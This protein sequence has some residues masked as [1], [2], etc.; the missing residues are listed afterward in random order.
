L[1]KILIDNVEY[2]TDDFSDELNSEVQM[3]QY[4]DRRILETQREL[5]TCQTAKN[6]YSIRVRDLLK[7]DHNHQSEQETGLA[8]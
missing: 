8:N 2:E 1:T 6:A 4:T 7:R 3:L 5:A